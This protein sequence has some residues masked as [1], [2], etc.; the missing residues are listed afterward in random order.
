MQKAAVG[1]EQENTIPFNNRELRSSK[2]VEAAGIEP[3]EITCAD[4]TPTPHPTTKP[5]QNNTLA[6]SPT[7]SDSQ[8][9]TSST[10]G[11]NNFQQLKCVPDVYQNIPAD[12]AK[13]VAEWEHL[14]EAIRAGIL[15]MICAA[16]P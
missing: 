2:M 9:A 4:T 7:E 14:P 3:V 6:T 8:K 15:A 1:E 11:D 10:Q 12:L 16:R 5:L 13:V